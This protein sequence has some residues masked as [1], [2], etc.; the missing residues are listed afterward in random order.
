MAVSEQHFRRGALSGRYRDARPLTELLTG[1][2][3]VAAWFDRCDAELKATPKLSARLLRDGAGGLSFAKAYYL[4]GARRLAA[5]CGRDHARRVYRHSAALLAAGVPVPTPLAYL[6]DG[7]R[8]AYYLCE[9]LTAA[10]DLRALL[11]AGEFDALDMRHALL[12]RI[13]DTLARLHRAGFAHGD[14]KWANIMVEPAGGQ[15]WLI[16][17]DGLAR[18]RWQR[19]QRYAR[20]LARFLVNA[21]EFGLAEAR[22]E[23]FV[24]R[25]A[26]QRGLAVAAVWQRVQ[27]PYDKLAARHRAKYGSAL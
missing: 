23:A 5:L 16:D 21:R 4:R 17:L 25:Y 20:D 19:E 27:A 7:R 3:E 10:T 11:D 2:L 24:E 6:R 1:E 15:L 22:I 18:P 13:A 26:A 14:M 8:A 12:A 9:A